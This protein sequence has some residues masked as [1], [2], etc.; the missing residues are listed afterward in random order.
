MASR[1]NSW[2]LVKT[3]SCFEWDEVSESKLA[4]ANSSI[5]KVSLEVSEGFVSVSKDLMKRFWIWLIVS[6]FTWS[7]CSFLFIL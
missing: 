4:V 7:S 1:V 3:L 2:S 6:S 5:W